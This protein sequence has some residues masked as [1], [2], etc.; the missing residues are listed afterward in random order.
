MLLVLYPGISNPPIKNNTWTASVSS[1]KRGPHIPHASSEY[2]ERERKFN[3]VNRMIRFIK[4]DMVQFIAFNLDY[5]IIW[6]IAMT[7]VALISYDPLD[8]FRAVPLAWYLIILVLLLEFCVAMTAVS[9]IRKI[10]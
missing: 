6:P 8:M 7:S 1:H 9:D 3:D 5:A 4:I 2:V 10:I